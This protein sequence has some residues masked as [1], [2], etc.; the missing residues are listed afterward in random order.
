MMTR[1]TFSRVLPSPLFCF[2]FLFLILCVPG[3]SGGDIMVAKDGMADYASISEAM[4]NAVEGQTIIIRPGVYRETL[5][6]RKGVRL[7]GTSPEECIIEPPEGT[8]AAI[9]VMEIGDDGFP[10]AIESLKIAG[11]IR[12]RKIQDVGIDLV[13][14]DEGVCVSRVIEGS[15]ADRAGVWRSAMLKS[16]NGWSVFCA[17]MAR[18]LMAQDGKASSVT[19]DFEAGPY[20]KPK[21]LLTSPR[22]VSGNWPRGIVI[23]DS[24]LNI[25]NCTFEK[26]GGDAVWI[27]GEDSDCRIYN[28]YFNENRGSGIVFS[29]GALGTARGNVCRENLR[30]I[31]VER[32]ATA[33]L[34]LSNRCMENRESGILFRDGGGGFAIENQCLQNGRS[35]IRVSDSGTHP[36]LRKNHCMKNVKEG[37]LF[38]NGASGTAMNNTCW[39]NGTDG[40]GIQGKGTFPMILENQARGN[41]GS[42]IS[43]KYGGAGIIERNHCESNSG[44]AIEISGKNCCPRLISNETQNNRNGRINQ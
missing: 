24:S 14:L 32:N 28:N 7:L 16:V 27:G 30:G 33:P 13:T 10:G 22:Y 31:T 43:V 23:I 39:R 44:Y 21:K 36:T 37:I 20:A 12:N 17:E 18:C 5:W 25:T 3:F 6:F 26:I 2:V 29:S 35:G 38:R 8:A 1:I 34:L 4:E 42:G 41:E 40:I 9:L 15:A 11:N 19:L